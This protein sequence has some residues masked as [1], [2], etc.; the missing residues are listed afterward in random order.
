MSSE[1]TGR[2]AFKA[3]IATAEGILNGGTVVV[4]DGII[5]AV[6]AADESPDHLDCEV[7]EGGDGFLVPGFIDVHV[8][9]GYGHD[10]MEAS[11]EAYEAITSFHGRNGT[12]RMLATTVTAPKEAIDAVLACTNDTIAR[13]SNGGSRGAK[14]QGVH[15]EG[16]FISP[17]W[18]GA[19]NPAFI[20]PP[21]KSWVQD[22]TARYPGLVKL[23]TLAPEE[24]GALE[25]IEHACGCGIVCACGHTNA[26]Y[27]QLLA[28]ADKGLRHA[29]HTFNAMTG[30]HHREPGTVGAVMTDDRIFAEVI[31]DGH[32]VHPAAIEL[33]TRAKPQDRLLLVTDAISAAGL[34]DGEYSLGG[35]A[36]TVRDGVA[37]LTHGGSL[38]GSTLTMIGAFR[39][40]VERIGLSIVDASRLAS[41]NPAKVLGIGQ[42]AG[43]IAAGKAA[44]LVLLA[45]DLSI[46][47]VY[48]EGSVIHSV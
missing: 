39:F 48:S 33:L 42:T 4:A 32:H 1:T 41:A 2:K 23:L 26:S 10:F 30:L 43:T 25:T 28:A 37:R 47:A 8:H 5:E 7:I 38:A 24:E 21:Q 29:V 9:G 6:Y 31:A 18:P 40:M 19:Q 20:V 34:G 45:P 3:N 35:L 22:W 13:Q 27:A 44:D 15:L 16:P 12:T 11:A 46:N 17:K 36:V 14:L